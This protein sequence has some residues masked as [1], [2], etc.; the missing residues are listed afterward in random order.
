MVVATLLFSLGFAPRCAAEMR[1]WTSAKGRT[2]EAEFVS[3]TDNELTLRKASGQEITRV[4][5]FFK[6]SLL[7][8]G[9]I[10]A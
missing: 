9:P 3:K 4:S 1:E 2:L 7:A 5:G 10:A 8:V 6:L